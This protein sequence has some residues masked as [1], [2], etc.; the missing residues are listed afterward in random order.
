MIYKKDYRDKIMKDKKTKQDIQM[1]YNMKKEEREYKNYVHTPIHEKEY[2][3]LPCNT[4]KCL[5]ND[6]GY[7]V[8][9]DVKFNDEN[10]CISAIFERDK[11]K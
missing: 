10:V 7:C 8:N 9:E 3:I 1:T 2:D 6:N 4:S 11:S 5:H